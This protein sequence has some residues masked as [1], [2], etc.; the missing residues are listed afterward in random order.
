MGFLVEGDIVRTI[1]IKGGCLV[2]GGV[3]PLQS[4]L[5]NTKDSH[6]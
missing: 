2:I 5:P 6:N 3:E 1:L 4:K